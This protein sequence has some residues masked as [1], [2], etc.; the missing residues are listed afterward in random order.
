M[1][2]EGANSQD[3]PDGGHLSIMIPAKGSM[4]VTEAG[5]GKPPPQT[6]SD[7]F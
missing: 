4:L 7:R 2:W 1:A 3:M 5:P 6:S